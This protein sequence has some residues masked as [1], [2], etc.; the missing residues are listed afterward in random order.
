MA[1]Q[2]LGKLL[3]VDYITKDDLE[4][5]APTIFKLKPMD[6]KQYMGVMAEANI[7]TDGDMSFSQRTMNGTID[8]GLV[9]WSNFKDGDG[10]NIPFS[11]ANFGQIP[12]GVLTEL[13]SEIITMS[14]GTEEDSKN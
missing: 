1:I 10:K 8:H 13:F 14:S 4:D 3:T 7:T 5:A 2:A 12:V 6:G 11:K 9:G